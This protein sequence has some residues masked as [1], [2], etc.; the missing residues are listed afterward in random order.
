VAAYDHDRERET[1]K[2]RDLIYSDQGV[3][4]NGHLAY[5]DASSAVR[6]GILVVHEAFGL[7]RHAM[8]RAERLAGLGYVALA[9]DM[10]GNRRQATDLPGAMALMQELSPEGIRSRIT[11]GL[12]ALRSQPQVDARKIGAIGFCFGGSAVLELARSG[13]DVGGVVSFHGVLAARAPIAGR[14]KA[15]ILVCHGSDDP[16][17]P[18][19]QM[20]EFQS[21]MRTAG[22]DWQVNIYGNAVHSFTN[23][24]MAN[25]GM[26]GISYHEPTDVRSWAAM[27]YFFDEVFA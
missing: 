14:I 15:K 18:N 23:R 13:A 27:R 25:S 2:T 21:E 5:D 1:L 3:S 24:D 26:P 20:T 7:G 10:F 19:E 6:P 22:A 8:E 12:K 16:L 9:V 17:V 11:A 4:M